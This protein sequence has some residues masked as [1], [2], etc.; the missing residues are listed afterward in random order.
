MHSLALWPRPGQRSGSAAT[1]SAPL[2]LTPALPLSQAPSRPARTSG[3]AMRPPWSPWTRTA[4]R[5]ASPRTWG[6][7]PRRPSRTACRVPSLCSGTVAT[8]SE[9]RWLHR[10]CWTSSQVSQ[11]VSESRRQSDCLPPSSRPSDQRSP[12]LALKSPSSIKRPRALNWPLWR[13]D[14]KDGSFDS[15]YS[16]KSLERFSGSK[17]TQ[18]RIDRE[19]RQS[20]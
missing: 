7:R 5:S 3:S 6:R 1:S 19:C 12:H 15:K 8:A 13:V 14:L 20:G 2:A 4:R 16:H 9:T 18:S 10:Y 17:H 11:S